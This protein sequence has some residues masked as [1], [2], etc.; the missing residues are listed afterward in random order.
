MAF[1]TNSRNF[2]LPIPARATESIFARTASYRRGPHFTDFT[3]NPFAKMTDLS[4]V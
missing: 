3:V 2:F 4:S 1:L